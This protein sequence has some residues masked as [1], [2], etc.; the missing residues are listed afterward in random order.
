[1]ITIIPTVA[2]QVTLYS[3]SSYFPSI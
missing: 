1:M 2:P 3:L